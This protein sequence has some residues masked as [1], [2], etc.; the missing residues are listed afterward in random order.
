MSA[1]ALSPVINGQAI[2]INKNMIITSKTKGNKGKQLRM[3]Y[4]QRE[5]K[6]GE[7]SSLK[8]K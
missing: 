8:A 3:V 5:A 7:P 4:I 6:L 2:I 1:L